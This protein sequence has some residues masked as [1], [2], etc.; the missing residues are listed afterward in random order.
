MN[1]LRNLS[2][3]LLGLMLCSCVRYGGTR[4]TLDDADRRTAYR[5]ELLQYA[6]ANHLGD[7][8]ALL[9][10]DPVALDTLGKRPF[11]PAYDLDYQPLLQFK[12]FGKDGRMLSH[13]GS[14]EGKLTE[15]ML[16]RV[17]PRNLSPIYGQYY[18]K[19][20]L[21]QYRTWN[22]A[23]VDPAQL[24]PADYYVVVWWSV[25]GGVGSAQLQQR[26]AQYVDEHPEKKWVLLPVNTDIL[27]DE[28]KPP[29]PVDYNPNPYR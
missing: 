13:Y 11:K 1:S 14:I 20:E 15:E 21:A 25:R 16:Q 2:P 23:P 3:F 4:S 27:Y 7:S 8:T 12:V 10:F 22:G 5:S 19:E 18:L 29:P 6:R 24:P 17:P 9:R 28:R 26:M